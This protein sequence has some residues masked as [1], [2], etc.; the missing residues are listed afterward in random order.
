MYVVSRYLLDDSALIE[1]LDELEVKPTSKILYEKIRQP[2]TNRMTSVLNGTRFFYTDPLE[3]G[4]YLP[5]KQNL[6]RAESPDL[7]LWTTQT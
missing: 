6:C 3:D 7:S 1:L 4:K 5:K 2:E